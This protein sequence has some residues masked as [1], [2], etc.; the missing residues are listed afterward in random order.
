MG[1]LRFRKSVKLAPGVKLNVNKKSVS[2]T[3]GA[4]G[5]HHTVG[6]KGARTTVGIPGTGLS[7]TSSSSKKR[8][9]TKEVAETKKGYSWTTIIIA[10]LA[11]S[12]VIGVFVEYWQYLVPAIVIIIAALFYFGGKSE[13]GN[14]AQQ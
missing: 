2:L 7:Y 1:L 9:P 3:T 5:L 12:L 8:T 4:R 14:D 11:I 13:G 10:V 6:S